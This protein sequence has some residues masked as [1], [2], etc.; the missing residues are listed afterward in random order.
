MSGVRAASLIAALALALAGCGGPDPD[1]VASGPR[2]SSPAGV[3][4]VVPPGWEFVPLQDGLR[5]VHRAPVGRGFPTL[6]VRRA[7]GGVAPAPQGRSFR[8]PLGAGRYR[9][10]RWAS[11]RGRGYRLDAVVE[12]PGDT[13]IVRGDLWDEG[14]RVD[15]EAFE[16]LL[17]PV[18]ETLRADR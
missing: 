9:Y 12:T 4:V 1:L 14:S 6:S 10:G 11:P 17:W 7:A 5:M 13:W 8:C 15:K 18:L 2:L 16:T 3:S